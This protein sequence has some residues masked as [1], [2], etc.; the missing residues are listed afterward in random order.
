MRPATRIVDR[1]RRQTAQPVSDGAAPLL[2]LGQLFAG[3]FVP[4]RLI[5]SGGMGQVYLVREIADGN[6]YALKRCSRLTERARRSGLHETL[7]EFDLLARV[8]HPAIVSVHELGFAADGPFF[9]MEFVPGRPAHEAVSAGDWPAIFFVATRAAEALEALHANSVLHG[10]VK[11]ANLLVVDAPSAGPPSAVKLVDFGLSAILE[12][13]HQQYP[14]TAGYAAPEVLDGEAASERS[15]LYGFGALLFH[16]I[17][18]RPAFAGESRA[19][20][21]ALQRRGAVSVRHLEVHGAPAGLVDL[22]MGLLSVDPGNRP[23]DA[24]EVRRQLGRLYPA[25]ARSLSERLATTQVVGRERELATFTQALADAVV[26]P[27]ISLVTGEAGAGKSALLTAMAVR[28]S[29]AKH[30]VVRLSGAGAIDPSRRF[31]TRLASGA[32]AASQDG[33]IDARLEQ[34][35][36]GL[37]NATAAQ[38]PPVILIDD[39]DLLDPPTRRL[40]RAAALHSHCPPSLWIL[41]GASGTELADAEQLLIGSGVARHLPLRPLGEPAIARLISARLAHA[42]PSALVAHLWEQ[43]RGHPGQ[44][45]ELL[46]VAA[47]NG[48]LAEEDDGI[49]VKSAALQALTS[50]CLTSFPTGAILEDLPPVAQAM[51]E[52]LALCGGAAQPELLE[53]IAPEHVLEGLHA[54]RQAGLVIEGEEGE[55]LLTPYSLGASLRARLSGSWRSELHR[56]ILAFPRLSNKSRF[57][58]AVGAGDSV[59]AITAAALALDFG[60][61]PDPDFALRAALMAETADPGRAVRWYQ[62]AA[63][64][65]FASGQYADAVV[66]LSRAAELTGLEAERS[67]IHERLALARFRAG[68]LGESRE[69]VAM[70]LR[71]VVSTALRARLLTTQAALDSAAGEHAAELAS[72]KQALELAGQSDDREA[73]GTAALTLA[74]AW[75][76]S[77]DTAQAERAAVRA[78]AA[79]RAH[80][81]GPGSVRALVA[82]GNVGR[83]RGD[84]AQAEQHYR[85]ALILARSGGFRLAISEALANLGVVLTQSGKWRELRQLYLEALRVAVEDNRPAAAALA[86]ANLSQTYGQ[87]GYARPALQR[88]RAAVRLARAHALAY[89]SFAWRTLAQAHRVGGRL[90]SADRAAR[91][92]L[93]L[94]FR[95][96][97]EEEIRWCRAEL[98]FVLAEKGE[99][100]EISGL[101]AVD[102]VAPAPPSTASEAMLLSL[103]GRAALHRNLT[104]PAKT[105]LQQLRDWAAEHDAP[106]LKAAALQLEAELHLSEGTVPKGIAKASQSLD[107]WRSL[108]ART[109][110]AKAIMGFATLALRADPTERAPLREWLE[111]AVATFRATGSHRELERAQ[112]LLIEWLQRAPRRQ[113]AAAEERQLMDLVWQLFHAMR[114]L[115][116][117]GRRAITLLVQQ[118]QAESGVVLLTDEE[119]GG[120][121]VLAEHGA[122][123]GRRWRRARRYSRK[124]VEEAIESGEAVLIKDAGE[125]ARALSESI[126][127]LKLRAIVCAPIFSGGK[128]LGAVYVDDSRRADAF[129]DG[130]RALLESFAQFMAIAIATGC[131]HANVVQTNRH[132]EKENKALRQELGARFRPEDMI[133]TSP[134]MKKVMKTIV[135]VATSN[136][137]VL[138]QG[139]TGTGKELA[140]H[141]IHHLSPRRDKP[142]V[143]VNCAAVTDSLRESEFFGVEHRRATGVDGHQGHFLNANHGTL[144]LDELQELPLSQQSALLRALSAHEVTPVGT[145]KRIR[146]DI[147]LVAATSQDLGELVQHGKFLRPLFERLNV[148]TIDMPP[149][150]QR[151]GDIEALAKHMVEVVATRDGRVPPSLAPEFLAT[152]AKSNWPGNVRGLL[153]YI[154]KVVALT[155]GRVLHPDPLPDDL[156]H[157]ALVPRIKGLRRL[158]DLLAAFERQILEDALERHHGVQARAARELDVSETNMRFR[159][160]QCGL[161]SR[162]EGRQNPRGG[163]RR[164]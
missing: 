146:I 88:A 97:P 152:L 77:G 156:Q 137:T 150:R 72:A 132:L 143:V 157:R 90:A 29:L 163:R 5:G 131:E 17:T 21:L 160:Q 12:K 128:A 53:Q 11:P 15:D 66:P 33:P 109:Q 86:L 141:I 134:A 51:A 22:V 129:D 32:E 28:A 125:D 40:V 44:T 120:Y 83:A 155:P 73:E 65:S 52:G 119:A 14:G 87:L 68:A 85:E 113:A 96:G 124:I 80:G 25:A 103:A 135:Q 24:R 102:P 98:G 56:R 43:T 18:G 63:D 118:L 99:W 6:V 110:R 130:D 133:G 136:A 161:L 104:G 92:A 30:A 117:L 55:L 2:P 140:A 9:T 101:C 116:E 35:L 75:L 7:R 47:M 3:R 94:A 105:M 95:R 64:W 10:D 71:Q 111:F 142:F 112:A 8:E 158:A 39:Y 149:L 34:A 45:I 127:D 57:G 1:P 81:A 91:R 153:N 61:E 107:L 79:F 82:L 138:L 20:T 162:H 159:L 106:A 108:S 139:E 58:H 36:A 151:K 69:L 122:V 41:A 42:A 147:R 16:L 89:E 70:G 154:T 144:F 93:T 121:R 26:G 76:H 54:L 145:S 67:V 59:A 78:S 126:R 123:D 100:A 74:A 46:R 50:D 114:D 164:K 31:L 62:L 13:A 27:R 48:V 60:A 148:V 84:L 4:L 23:R 49:T 38:P 115:P 37:R 19:E